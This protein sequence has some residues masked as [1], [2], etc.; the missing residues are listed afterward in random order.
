[1]PNLYFLKLKKKLMKTIIRSLTF[2]LGFALCMGCQKN[3]SNSVSGTTATLPRGLTGIGGFSLTSGHVKAIA[4]DWKKTGLADHILLYTPGGGGPITVVENQG[5]STSPN[6]VIVYSNYLPNINLNNAE[7]DPTNDIGG[8]HLIAYDYEGD[9]NMDD[10]LYYLPGSGQYA[11]LTH[12]CPACGFT[13]AQGNV[14]VGGGIAGYNLASTADKIIAYDW[15]GNF[16]YDGLICYRPGTGIVWVMQGTGNGALTVTNPGS[17][18]IGG[19]DLKGATDQIITLDYQNSGT[20]KDLALYRP[21]VGYCWILEHVNNTFN[22]VFTTRS[23]FS[24]FSLTGTADRIIS[25]DY[26]TVGLRNTLF[27]FRPGTGIYDILE[28]S[29]NT[30]TSS[31]SSLGQGF[32]GYPFSS[33]PAAGISGDR[34]F[35]L[36][37]GEGRYGSMVPY[38]PGTNRIDM[39]NNEGGNVTL[40]F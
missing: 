31:G 39:L 32:A 18:G 22:A 16:T 11:M 36:D 17:S 24:K 34:A 30:Y 35:A 25:W 27:C 23:G 19:Y 3:I 38:A 4:F 9:G 5:T 12:T 33:L 1:M 13:Y 29:G 10:L 14:G 15:N 37:Q 8:D 6:Y 21:G 28:R 2:V 7:S 20:P 26:R 40:V